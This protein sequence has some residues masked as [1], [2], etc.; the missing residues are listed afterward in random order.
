VIQGD[1]LWL[2]PLMNGLCKKIVERAMKSKI[3]NLKQ[4]NN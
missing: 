3:L 2:P 4:L 1:N